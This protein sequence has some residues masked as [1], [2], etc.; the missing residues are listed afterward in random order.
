MQTVSQN[1][2]AFERKLVNGSYVGVYVPDEDVAR[3][4]ERRRKL[5]REFERDA[6]NA[7]G[8]DIDHSKARLLLDL[9][10]MYSKTWSFQEI[11]RVMEDLYGLIK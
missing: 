3:R 1:R 6:L 4:V 10:Y 2:A 9:S 11:F 5:K 8:L 7:L